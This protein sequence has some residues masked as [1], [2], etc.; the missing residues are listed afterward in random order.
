MQNVQLCFLLIYPNRQWYNFLSL[1][2][3]DRDLFGRKVQFKFFIINNRSLYII[4]SKKRNILKKKKLESPN[5][6]QNIS[7]DPS[8]SINSPPRTQAE[9]YILLTMD[10]CFNS[11]QKEILMMSSFCSQQLPNQTSFRWSE[12]EIWSPINILAT[13]MA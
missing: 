8:L 4:F 7:G 10:L 2:T 9:S 6:N 13:R 3:L 11:L 5:N 1:S 12:V